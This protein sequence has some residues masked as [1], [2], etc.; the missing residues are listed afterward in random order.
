VDDVP[1]KVR[2]P[3]AAR[4]PSVAPTPTTMLRTN[5]IKDVTMLPP[6][7]LGF[8]VGTLLAIGGAT[9]SAACFTAVVVLAGTAVGQGGAPA[10]R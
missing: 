1:G 5:R 7:L 8:S 6:D 3:V 4:K 10:G 9:V 2:E